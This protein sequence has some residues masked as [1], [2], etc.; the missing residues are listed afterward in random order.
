MASKRRSLDSTDHEPR[1]SVLSARTLNRVR[2]NSQRD[3]DEI[4]NDLPPILRLVAWKQFKKLPMARDA[5]FLLSLL[6]PRATPVCTA[7]APVALPVPAC[8]TTSHRWPTARGPRESMPSSASATPCVCP[9][10]RGCFPS[11]RAEHEIWR[12]ARRRTVPNAADECGASRAGNTSSG[13]TGSKAGTLS[14]R[15]GRLGD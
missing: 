9:P 2:H 12:Y 4:T 3:R 5:C 8:S 1:D 14:L 13:A 10:A 11:W 7:A 6:E 15:Y